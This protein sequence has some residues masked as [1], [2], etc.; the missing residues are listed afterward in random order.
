[1]FLA[2]LLITSG[3]APVL[4]FSF[5]IP[6]PFIYRFWRATNVDHSFGE[7]CIGDS[8]RTI[9]RVIKVHFSYWLVHRLEHVSQHLE[10]LY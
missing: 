6:L 5:V 4:S 3:F 8:S 1:M 7:S 2:G 9:D 10:E